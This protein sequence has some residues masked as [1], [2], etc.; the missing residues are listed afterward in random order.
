MFVSLRLALCVSNVTFV[1]L[2]E[3]SVNGVFE[4]C[5]VFGAAQK[6]QRRRRRNEMKT[7][8]AHNLD[9]IEGHVAEASHHQQRQLG[10]ADANDEQQRTAQ[11]EQSRPGEEQPCG[12]GAEGVEHVEV[13][14]I[15]LVGFFLCV[16]LY[17]ALL[18][19]REFPDA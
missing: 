19:G 3:S 2:A 4:L 8:D 7:V 10:Q 14:V 15:C 9:G 11:K 16:C 18:I 12:S 6:R 5:A 13:G 1:C 17:C